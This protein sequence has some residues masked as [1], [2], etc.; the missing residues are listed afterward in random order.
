MPGVPLLE[1]VPLQRLQGDSVQHR[2][3]GRLQHHRRHR[4]LGD[5]LLAD[6]LQRLHPPGDA[7]APP[8]ARF[9]AGEVE[10]RPRRREVVAPL[11]AERKELVGH[12][13]TQLV[14]AAVV[15]VTRAVAVPPVV[16]EATNET[17]LDAVPLETLERHAFE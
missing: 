16:L 14:A 17:V 12:D 10:A 2:L 13:R 15:V 11:L 8:V 7:D 1:G 9:E 3:V 5:R 4:G 6:R